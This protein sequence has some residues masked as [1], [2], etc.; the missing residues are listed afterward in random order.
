MKKPK[1]KSVD[2]S[3]E[4]Y[5]TLV[6]RNLELINENRELTEKLANL[7]TVPGTYL[8]KLCMYMD[9]DQ[10][11]FDFSQVIKLIQYESPAVLTKLL[12]QIHHDLA[13]LNIQE[14]TAA[15][16]RHTPSINDYSTDTP[17]LLYILKAM[18]EAIESVKSIVI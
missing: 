8:I 7:K 5:L 1:R 2:I 3:P 10:K 11:I 16:N 18:A 14:Q 15:L 4:N 17:N 9:K 6:N 13:V 12:R